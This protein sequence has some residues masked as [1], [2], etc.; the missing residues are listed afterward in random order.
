MGEFE[1]LMPNVQKVP[2]S[3]QLRALVENSTHSGV[4]YGMEWGISESGCLVHRSHYNP[5]WRIEAIRTAGLK[6]LYTTRSKNFVFTPGRG[7]VGKAFAQQ[8]ILFV[9]DVRSI[10]YD[11][12]ADA[13][14]QEFVRIDLAKEFGIQSVVF[15][16]FADGV[17][18]IGST[19]VAASMTD[20]VW[21][22]W[23]R[24]ACVWDH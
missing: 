6:S 11:T 21:E 23:T 10:S 5:A 20:L 7:Y 12:V 3:N 1:N 22:H 9:G 15:L 19:S 14:A 4:C 2:R 18:E 17:L 24:I 13:D 8:Q 16:P